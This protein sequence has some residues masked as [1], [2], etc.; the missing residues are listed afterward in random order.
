MPTKKIF[1]LL[2][3]LFFLIILGC[4]Q[5]SEGPELNDTNTK[6]FQSNHTTTTSSLG[7][8]GPNCREKRDVC[9]NYSYNSLEACKKD[10]YENYWDCKKSCPID[11]QESDCI[12]ACYQK[13]HV[14]EK[15]CVTASE[16]QDSACM[17]AYYFCRKSCSS[18]DFRP[19]SQC[20]NQTPEKPPNCV[21]ITFEKARTESEIQKASEEEANCNRMCYNAYQDAPNSCRDECLYTKSLEELFCSDK[22]SQCNRTCRNIFVECYDGGYCD[23][24]EDELDACEKRCDLEEVACNQ[25]IEPVYKQCEDNCIGVRD[26]CL[27]GCTT[28]CS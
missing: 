11:S 20:S 6:T 1:C 26:Q 5:Q 12:N 10:T 27:P 9:R 23:T 19:L 17:S 22:A 25:L 21:S 2:P 24:K 3:L 16:N 4:T 28:L 8:D 15:D 18:I 7:D 14:T 13:S